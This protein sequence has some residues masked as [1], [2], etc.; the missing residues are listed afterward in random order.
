MRSLENRVAIVTGAGSAGDGIGNG[1]AAALLLAEAGCAVVCVDMSQESAQ[2][3]VSMIESEGKGRA[4]FMTGDIS[5]EAVCKSIVDKT[6]SIYGHLDILVNNVGIIG[7]R[8]NATEVDMA[9]WETGMRVNV[10]SMV[11]MSK[12][13]IPQMSKNEGEYWRGSIVNVGSVAGLMGGAPNLLYATS[14][15]AVGNLTVRTLVSG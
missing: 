2:L 14:K 3:T 9:G 4:T 12:Y 6:I 15:G 13:A 8:G 10:G 7:A 5:D 11:M 1:R